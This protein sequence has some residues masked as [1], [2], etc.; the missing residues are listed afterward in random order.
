MKYLLIYAA[1]LT[2]L[3]TFTGGEEKGPHF[4]GG[5]CG[6]CHGKA[7]P[8]QAEAAGGLKNLYNRLCMECHET[9]SVTCRFHA[10][11]VPGEESVGQFMPLEE[12]RFYCLTCHDARIQCVKREDP[13][14]TANPLF[15]R[16]NPKGGSVKFCF[17]CHGPERYKVF[18]VHAGMH[19]EAESSRCLYCHREPGGETRGCRACHK[20][21]DHPGEADH[22]VSM[23][24]GKTALP[25]GEERRIECHTCHDPHASGEQRLLLRQ[26]RETFCSA[27]HEEEME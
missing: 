22:L 6:D 27:C 26:K 12:G 17:A 5:R 16:G 18:K 15:L 20:V 2:T 10:S 11:I 24:S 23:G 19:R 13:A 3:A 21:G 14:S 4:H 8:E 7:G 1:V 9:P 25:L